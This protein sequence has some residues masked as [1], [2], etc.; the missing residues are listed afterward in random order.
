[1]HVLITKLSLPL[2][3]QKP[4]PLSQRKPL[5]IARDDWQVAAGQV[6]GASA[7]QLRVAEAFARSANGE[8][9]RPM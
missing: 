9:R 2:F 4:H 5:L 1:M 3:V 7:T 6:A 8:G